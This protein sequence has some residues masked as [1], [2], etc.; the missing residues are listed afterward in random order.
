MESH[1]DD[2]KDHSEKKHIIHLQTLLC[3]DYILKKIYRQDGPAL[4][5]EFDP[6]GNVLGH[7][8]GM[9]CAVLKFFLCL[10]TSFFKISGSVMILICSSITRCM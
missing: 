2:G 9:S 5:K 8:T 1:V 7:C 3:K 4:G 6:P 10:Y